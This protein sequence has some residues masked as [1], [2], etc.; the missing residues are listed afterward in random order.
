HV[1]HGPQRRAPDQGPQSPTWRGFFWP[2]ISAACADPMASSWTPEYVCEAVEA[3]LRTL[4]TTLAR[5][6]SFANDKICFLG[7]SE[8]SAGTLRRAHT[9]HPIA[10]VQIEYSPWALEIEQND[11]LGNTRELGV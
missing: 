11:L 2:L 1:R 3:R 10:A 6:P 7:L 8:C 4:Q 5:W 9:V